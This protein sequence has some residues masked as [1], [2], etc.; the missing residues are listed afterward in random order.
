MKP[1]IH[2]LILVLLLSTSNL[3]CQTN[4][5]AK[6][7]TGGLDDPSQS[8]V[9]VLVSG[10]ADARPCPPEYTNVIS[11]TNLF[12][13]DEQELLS[14][15][16]IEYGYV[17]TNSGPPG[18]ILVSYETW[19]ILTEW[20]TNWQWVARFQFTNSGFSDEV[21]PG[22]E[23]FR[24][25]V[26]NKAGDGF[27]LGIIPNPPENSGFGG[28]GGPEYWIHQIRHDVKDGLFVGVEHGNRCSQ[29]MRY[30]NGMAV[31]K[32]LFWDPNYPRLIL[33]KKFTQPYDIDGIHKT[34]DPEEVQKVA[35]A[36]G[37]MGKRDEC[38][39][40]ARVFYKQI[41]RWPTNMIE[42]SSFTHSYLGD[43]R[44][45]L[46]DESSYKKAAFT[47]TADGDLNIE[48]QSREA[49]DVLGRTVVNVD[50]PKQ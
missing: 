24:H 29:W 5:L 4:Y 34:I 1:E 6:K 7:I 40:A 20:G 12:T 42:L 9:E 39:H 48:Y 47:V 25:K 43:P 36:W 2:T 35:K 37:I 15:I 33:W 21:R 26:R 18:S 49:S 28:G 8:N 45:G 46:F 27:D 13:P 3:F 41:G 30:S 14:K 44:L 11:N 16:P 19:P 17:T 31:D 22:G 38:Y 50:K 32:Q 10:M 23:L